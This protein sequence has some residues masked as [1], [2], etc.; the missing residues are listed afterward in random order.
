MQIGDGR[1]ANLQIVQKLA[2]AGIIR[3]TVQ[4]GIVLHPIEILV[5]QGNG[6]TEHFD[7]VSLAS[8]QRETAGEIVVRGGI[9]RVEPDEL[10]IHFQTRIY[11]SGLGVDVRQNRRH[12]Y[13]PGHALVQALEKAK[14]KI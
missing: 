8:L 3:Q 11:A 12:P 10:T 5:T 2:K 4:V 9:L 1:L 13:V 7:R 6:I 14:L